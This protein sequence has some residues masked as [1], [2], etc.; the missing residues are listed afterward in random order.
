MRTIIYVDG[1][2]LY[3]RL[4]KTRPAAKWLNLRSLAENLLHRDHTILEINYYTARISSRAHDPEAPARQATYLA[5]LATEPTILIHEG[6]FLTSTPW[7]PLADPPS[8]KPDGYQWTL[9]PP[10]VVRVTKFE[11][12]GSDVNLAAHLVRDACLDRFDVAAV[13]TNDTDLV[14]PIRI[15]TQELGRRIGLLTPVSRPHR[16]LI[17][18]SSFYLHIRPGHLMSAQ[19]PDRIE[20]RSGGVIQ[21]PQTWAAQGTQ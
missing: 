1:L 10:E 13:L 18:V 14:E 9:P 12:K 7:M 5:A 3:Y 6:N 2:N 19:F 11:E 17:E 20:T 8:A 21:R 15:A 4:L 16:S